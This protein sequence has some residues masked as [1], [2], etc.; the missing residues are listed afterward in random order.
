MSS[1]NIRLIVEYDGAA[2]HGWQQQASVKTVQE[3]LRR[4]IEVVLRR[5]VA[6][7]HAAGRTDSGVHAR[8]QVVTFKTDILPD[9]DRLAKAISHIMRPTLAV[10]SA[11]VVSDN[12][13]P[14]RNKNRKEYHYRIL[15][16]MT[17]PVIDLGRVWHV[18]RI[19]D[20]DRM[21]AEA[22]ILVGTHDFSGLRGSGCTARSPIKTI[23]SSVLEIDGEHLTYKVIGSG[24]LKH[25]VRNIVGTLV[26]L[27]TPLGCEGGD[28]QQILESKN[29]RLA[30]PTAPPY[31]LCMVRVSYD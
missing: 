28:M 17:P 12:F 2:F 13:H 3:E 27:A 23:Y 18:P 14:G 22:A 6:P 25:M 15:N 1:Y 26:F 30:G 4:V 11:E 9:L 19:L 7:L 10:R 8:G 5:R 31:G 24:F 20:I 21:K 16:S 29:R